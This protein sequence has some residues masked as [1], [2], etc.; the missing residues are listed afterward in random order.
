MERL[1]VGTFNKKSSD[2]G[3]YFKERVF[4]MFSNKPIYANIESQEELTDEMKPENLEFYKIYFY[5]SFTDYTIL[6]SID[7][8]QINHVNFFQN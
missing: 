8:R 7:I 4:M 1:I 2:D 5:N 3:E 6:D